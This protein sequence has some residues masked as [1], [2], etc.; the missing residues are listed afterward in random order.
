[1]QKSWRVYWQKVAL[2]KRLAQSSVRLAGLMGKTA[3]GEPSGPD[4]VLQFTGELDCSN[5]T[6][7]DEFFVLGDHFEHIGGI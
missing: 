6:D 7:L 4:Y 3:P 5:M 1:M 2:V